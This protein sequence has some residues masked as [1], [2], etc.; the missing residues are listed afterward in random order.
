[1]KTRLLFT[2][3]LLL[4]SWSV[5]YAAPA[6]PEQLE[7]EQGDGAK[8]KAKIQGDEFQGWVEAV[9]S[10][11][12]V[13][14]N[15]DSGQWEY[16]EKS[17][18]GTLKGSGIKVDPTGKYAP[19]FLPKGVKPERDVEREQKQTDSIREKLKN[20]L[21]PSFSSG[22]ETDGSQI[23]APLAGPGDW[24]PVPVAGTRSLLVILVNFANRSLVTTPDSWYQKVFDTT[25][26]VKSVANFYRENSFGNLSIVPAFSGGSHPGVVSVTVADNHPNS[27]QSSNY[28]VETTIISHALA[29]AAA[30]VDLS[31]FDPATGEVYLIYAGY[32]ASGSAKTPNVW[33]HAWSGSV[34]GGPITITNWALN[35]ELNNS[36][37]QHPMGVIAHEL[38]HAL[39]GLPDLY[40]TS[41]FNAG[42]G[43]FS[44]MASGSWG[45]VP[46][47]QGGTTPVA[48]DAWSREYLGWTAPLTPTS[49]GPVTLSSA[50]A[51]ADNALKLLNPTT[52]SSE[53]WLAENRHPTPGGWDEGITGLASGYAGGLLITHIDITAGTLGSNNINRYV[54][55]VPQGV[56]PVQASTSVC[57]MLA[58]GS[59]SSCR[60]N[61]LTT[62]YS[63]N[64][65]D[66]SSATVPSSKYYSGAVSNRGISSISAKGSTMTANVMVTL[67]TDAT[68]PLVTAFTVPALATTLTIPVSAYTASDNVAVASYLITESSIA[69]LSSNSGWS[70]TAPASYTFATAGS[71][72]LYAWAKDTTGNVSLAKAAAVI[73]D[74][75]APLVTAIVAP[76]YYNSLTVPVTL[77]VTDN[78]KVAAYQV[79]KSSTPPAA[80][81]LNW[82]ST[83]TLSCTFTSLGS[84]TYYGW[85]KDT[86]GNVSLSRS[87]TVTLE[88]GIPAV[89]TFTVDALVAGKVIPIRAFSASDNAGGSGIAGYRITETATAPL[90]TATGWSATVPVS[91]TTAIGGAK[92]LYAW[93][94][95]AAGNVSPAR[96]GSV[97]A[98]ATKP[99]VTLFTA[100]AYATTLTIPISAYAATDN[101]AVASYLVTETSAV[102]LPS[103]TGWNATPRSSYTFATTGV[104][105]L[106]AWAKDTA[107]NVS[108]AKVA[109]V[110]I[111][112]TPPVVTAVTAPAFYNK[113]TVPVTV[114]ATDNIKLVGYLVTTSSAAPAASDLNW[115]STATL[116]CTFAGL[117]SNTFYAWAKDAAGY[118]SLSRSGTVVIETSVPAVNTFTVDALVAGRVI[119][120]RAFSAT[121]NIGGSGIAGYRITETSTAPLATATGWSATAPASY[122]TASGGSKLLYA[123]TKDA[124]GNVSPARTAS[125][126]AD[127]TKPVVTLF[128]VPAT[129]TALT[130]PITSYTA[131]DN[132]AVASYLVT[133]SATVPLPSNT[134]WAA[135]K[136]AGYTFATKGIKKLYAWAKDTA[137]NVSAAKYV[138]LTIY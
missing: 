55:G 137:G 68:K 16:A 47:E 1:M 14:K 136:P 135:S 84:N 96:T 54:S 64:N 97:Y 110:A 128:T 27:G 34:T 69:P 105:K 37:A 76:A 119:P 101:L 72:K 81:D 133:E 115:K 100:P 5:S 24:V 138:T 132:L 22:S 13:L 125:V 17:P 58:S 65:S 118:V 112:Q 36:D 73:I 90:A 107:G 83:A 129:T 45:R 51:S 4:F 98:D 50:L 2:M 102:P 25:P 92:V 49:S 75:A 39:C 20:R 82:K 130:V 40:D 93:A 120:V 134:G 67:T 99:V 77:K 18:D 94:K 70:V 89:N 126:Y 56:V 85:A 31:G 60:G 15:K 63:G 95:D 103:N 124:A 57:N 11:H 48:L 109:A 87:A 19:S 59:S 33:A 43:H 79:T 7:I 41:S 9:D 44:L 127:A 114:K 32:E 78:V 106:Y 74:Q 121:D 113:L 46:G 108:A 52:S 3:M 104:K 66:F 10:G 35:G 30:T 6:A 111:D 91:Y 26:G 23:F 80:S 86:A 8:F 53:Y 28:S 38:G 42:L 21:G 62:Y 122:T 88:N 12:T 29:Q 71:K 117:G 131:S 123:W 61:Y 116:S